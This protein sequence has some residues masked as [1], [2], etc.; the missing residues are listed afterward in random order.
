MEEDD[1][2]V[3]SDSL[4]T[5]CR[6]K[7]NDETAKLE[8]SKEKKH[9][10]KANVYKFV[11]SAKNYE[12]GTVSEMLERYK[13]KK[14]PIV[15]LNECQEIQ[16]IGLS[17]QEKANF[18]TCNICF[19]AGATYESADTHLNSMEHI[20]TY[21]DEYECDT[22]E[23]IE[24]E[25]RNDECEKY[26]RYRAAAVHIFERDNGV[27]GLQK[28]HILRLPM[29]VIDGK[30][31][32]DIE[33]DK[34]VTFQSY[35]N[36]ANRTILHCSTCNEITPVHIA[37]KYTAE[38][39][40]INHWDHPNHQRYATIKSIIN[41]FDPQEI[42]DEFKTT[43]SSADLH[44]IEKDTNM[45][46][47]SQPCGYRHSV[48]AG[49]ETMCFV[50]YALV[51]SAH[52]IDH[53]TSEFHSM[54]YL[55]MIHSHSS[56]LTHQYTGEE[57]R[58][59]ALTMLLSTY[60]LE[61]DTRKVART[62]SRLPNSIKMQLSEDVHL[63]IDPPFELIDDY[64][65]TT[66]KMHR[67][68]HSCSTYVELNP[69]M[70][71]V[72]GK[73]SSTW[74]N[75]VMSSEHFAT[76]AMKSRV[77]FDPSFLVPYPSTINNI[78]TQEKGV[79]KMNKDVL[80]QT[81]CD[82][83]L[84]Y[85]IEDDNAREVTC[86]LCWKVFSNNSVFVNQHIRSFDHLK[87]YIYHKENDLVRILLGLEP[88][89][90]KQQFLL[91]FLQTHSGEFPKRM[92]L[93]SKSKTLE[94]SQWSPVSRR[95]FCSSL[96]PRGIEKEVYDTLYE[97]VDEVSCDG[98]E[99]SGMSAREALLNAGMLIIHTER[100]MNKGLGSIVCRCENCDLL[101]VA[102]AE[103]WQHDIFTAHM[104]TDEHKRRTAVNKENTISAIGILSDKSS[105][106][107]KPFIQK[108]ASKKVVWQWNQTTKQHEYVASVVG[109]E[110]IIERR[111]PGMDFGIPKQ[112]ADFYCTLCMKVFPKRAAELESHIKEMNHCVNW[113]HK[114][115][116]NQIREFI[117][118]TANQAADKGK[119]YRKFL[120]GMLKE[121]HPPADYCISI[122]DPIGVEE[123]KQ[124]AILQKMQAEDKHKKN[125][126]A[127]ERAAAERARKNKEKEA[128][129][130]NLEK[131]NEQNRLKRLEEERIRQEKEK[132]RQAERDARLTYAR[133]NL[134][135][136]ET[137]E[138]AAL[139]SRLQHASMIEQQKSERNSIDV[140]QAKLEAEK[141]R[142]LS[143]FSN[144]AGGLTHQT[145]PA[146]VIR[147]QLQSHPPPP[148]VPFGIASNSSAFPP[149]IRVSDTTGYFNQAQQPPPVSF[150]GVQQPTFEHNRPV[151]TVFSMNIPNLAP[152]PQQELAAFKKRPSLR[153]ERVDP[154][155]H[156]TENIKNKTH[157]LN[158]MRKKGASQILD[159]LE[160][161]RAFSQ[162]VQDNPDAFG[163]DVV[164][165]IVCLDDPS[166]DSYMCTICDNW[167]DPKGMI[168]HLTSKEHK[169]A[170]LYHKHP[171]Y[172]AEVNRVNEK[173]IRDNVFKNYTND[174][175]KQNIGDYMKTR[176]KTLIDKE[177]IERL[178]PGYED[179]FYRKDNPKNEAEAW[180]SGGF[181]PIAGPSIVLPKVVHVPMFVDDND[182]KME[183]NKKEQ[184][185]RK[186][187]ER[188]SER[189]REHRRR[190]RSRS[191]EKR[192]QR[193]RSH[194]R[195][196]TRSRSRSR[197]QH[198][199]SRRDRRSR[200]RSSSRSSRRSRSRERPSHRSKNSS[201]TEQ[202][203]NFLS[204]LGD[205]KT[206]TT[207][208]IHPT[209]SPTADFKSK[210]ATVRDLAQS[211][212]IRGTQ[213][214]GYITSQI[215]TPA[216]V[217][218]TPSVEELRRNERQKQEA[219][220]NLKR[221]VMGVLMGLEKLLHEHNG[222]V[223]RELILREYATYGL[224]PAEG[225][226]EVD[227][228]I[229]EARQKEE[230]RNPRNNISD[231]ISSLGIGRNQTASYQFSQPSH[232]QQTVH[233]V[234]PVQHP[235]QQ[236]QQ[237]FGI[238]SQVTP[239][240]SAYS[241]AFGN[242]SASPMAPL[243]QQSIQQ[244][245]F[246]QSPPTSINHVANTS[247]MSEESSLSISKPMNGEESSDDDDEEDEDYMEVYKL[248]GKTTEPRKKRSQEK[249]KL[250]DVAIPGQ[251][252]ALK[253]TILPN[254]ARVGETTIPAVF[255]SPAPSE[256]LSNVV[257]TTPNCVKSTP[258]QTVQNTAPI[259]EI[260]RPLLESA[261][262][263]PAPI[264][265]TKSIQQ[266][267]Q[268]PHMMYQTQQQV[269]Q[270]NPGTTQYQQSPTVYQQQQ[271]QVPQYQQQMYQPPHQP[272]QYA[273]QYSIQQ[274]AFQQQ[275][276]HQQMYQQPFY[277]HPQQQ[278][279][280]QSQ[281][282]QPRAQN[283]V[284]PSYGIGGSSQQYYWQPQ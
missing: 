47:L 9:I 178:W 195:S 79:W 142:L 88:D 127:N 176:M 207:S 45:W 38:K 206:V 244:Q 101:I 96:L 131:Q 174:L 85:M 102:N 179:Y 80:I 233:T 6:V 157:L 66:G 110:D 202:T 229:N 111:Y 119:E 70:I 270:M 61:N 144:I 277:Q 40:R 63:Y 280:Q 17:S 236:K 273:Q 75:H 124:F 114:Y 196:R 216:P 227:R 226:R 133:E 42:Y 284:V 267:M 36:D 153:G 78:D 279:Y 154:A 134:H 158:Y 44:W 67:F 35:P 130:R 264:A 169:N 211:G 41:E 141:I 82:V 151:N 243:N 138:E 261:L 164:A 186:E 14:I 166:L 100:G 175:K 19:V 20:R 173:T 204:K 52:I 156:N 118:L 223:P 92:S 263:I 282:S 165:E 136:F 28:P 23:Q 187:E 64:K 109:L 241:Q 98:E 188:R 21:M 259:A 18:W 83:G 113:V 112:Q 54:K 181:K 30:Q 90:K 56:F 208:P 240:I 86:Q 135:K 29:N 177:T 222:V 12:E 265:V 117:K 57:R 46:Y 247:G 246:Y 10:K 278:Y 268:Q 221:K 2:A 58:A 239:T 97:L 271:Q 163:I 203:E 147:P 152:P 191:R 107:V 84:E 37:G 104:C 4:C 198:Y 252:M 51:D 237:Q 126:E 65:E 159:P 256:I 210:L 255:P 260:S 171:M 11:F 266:P 108:D 122:Y 168:H 120:S 48:Q 140:Q 16:Q 145:D 39:A 62:L 25:C 105:Y 53:F 281:Q 26:E 22:K 103:T 180:S 5:C 209:T 149:G 234:Q 276:Q 201:W 238:K 106:T 32:L 224:D 193:S 245:P 139:K 192:R 123:R 185:R 212:I 55:N 220:A 91:E 49:K 162:N 27:E 89:E 7:C 248:I 76:A 215:E 148:H 3:W 13:L 205:K 33:E 219:D 115:R 232:Y 31:K 94:L 230:V 99:K 143:K 262:G 217:A 95:V 24:A 137:K 116:P 200:S 155:I 146:L 71:E 235:A 77:Y 218:P 1:S 15:G 189:S 228:F 184:L 150:F 129:Q 258:F 213:F 69:K 73:M 161:P 43:E 121:I 182:D 269:H 249:E 190:S 60:S 242:R 68:C 231:V 272:S 197:D 253:R 257:G 59:K 132:Q 8:H 275:Q 183:T 274:P 172:H 81:Q 250:E 283:D 170:Y 128:R 254:G 194:R 50:C 125:L 167:S 251:K 199:R 87:Q 34:D 93:Y 214:D 74:K 160:I 225:D 72:P